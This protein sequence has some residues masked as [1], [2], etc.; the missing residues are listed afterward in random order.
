MGSE[1]SRGENARRSVHTLRC[2]RITAL[3]LNDS[4]N[5]NEKVKREDGGG[6][7]QANPD[8]STDNSRQS[9]LTQAEETY[10]LQRAQETD[11]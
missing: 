6:K 8:R 4:R 9:V 7:L 2:G 1:N 10:S 11:K 5:G 3:A